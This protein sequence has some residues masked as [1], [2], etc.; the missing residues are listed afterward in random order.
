MV[1]LT[2]GSNIA[3][4][5]PNCSEFPQVEM[6]A[7]TSHDKII[8]YVAERYKGDWLSYIDNWFRQLK[9]MREIQETNGSAFFKK[10]NITI[11]GEELENYIKALEARL[12]VTKCLARYSYAQAEAQKM[13]NME[14]ASG[15][16]QPL[17]SATQ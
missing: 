4:A 1:V 8:D 2:F 15:E 12:A 17:T 13:E 16:E 9:M 14:T 3:A 5:V 7:S 11:G 10:Q 6:W